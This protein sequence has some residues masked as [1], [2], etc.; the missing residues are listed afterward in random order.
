MVNNKKFVRIL[1]IVLAFIMLLSVAMIAISALVDASASAN[2]RNTRNQINELRNQRGEL[3]R[4]K[5]EVETRIRAIESQRMTELERK[6]ILDARI[7]L[8]GEE[9]DNISSTIDYFNLLIREKEYEV[10]NAQRRENE[11]LERYRSRVRNMEENG[12]ISYLEIIFDSTSFSDM[13]ARIDFV[14]DIMRSDENAYNNLVNARNATAARKAELEETK[15]EL[16]EEKDLLEQMEAELL[17]QLEEAEAIIQKM[18]D[19]IEE[20]RKLHAQ[21]REDED[22]IQSEINDQL[23][24]LARQEAAE[25]A[26]AAA[27]RERERQRQAAAGGGSVTGSGQL[28]WPVSGIITSG[29][30]VRRHPVF[31]DMRMHNGIDIGAPHGTRVVAA[32][33]GTVI[34]SG[35][36]SSYGNYVVLNH[37]N[38]M[39]TLYAHFSTRSV[40]VGD[41]VQRGQQVGLVGSTG[42]STGPHLHFEVSVNGTRVNPRLHLP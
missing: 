3:T 16:D 42:V 27:A 22:K 25:R 2:S 5:R 36:N 15:E 35:Y 7:I 13:L 31:R 10:F 1:A 26:A 9:I 34:I 28:M 21:V 32:D 19:D 11:Q 29:F 17:E 18:E 8:T 6:G 12:M 38:G 23:R 33:A 24:L 14:V 4:Q 40:R 20:S 37:G 41:T 39:T 30:G